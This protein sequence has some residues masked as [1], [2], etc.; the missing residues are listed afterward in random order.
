MGDG[1]AGA[2]GATMV[3]STQRSIQHDMQAQMERAHLGRPQVERVCA[4]VS[5]SHLASAW[6][7]GTN[8]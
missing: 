2:I 6:S 3:S 5:E 7:V 4:Q 1:A 8:L